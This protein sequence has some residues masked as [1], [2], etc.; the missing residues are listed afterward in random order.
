[1]TKS[2]WNLSKQVS[3][4]DPSA[5]Q[6]MGLEFLAQWPKPLRELLWGRGFRDE[7][8]VEAYFSPSLQNLKNPLSLLG[9]REACIRLSEA[10]Q[11]KEKV[12]IYADFDLDGTSGCALLK[13][14]LSDLGFE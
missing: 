6:P 4:Q 9:M 8:E 1:M 14:A 13:K 2:D 10:L 11:K 7:A 3:H 12:C 5:E